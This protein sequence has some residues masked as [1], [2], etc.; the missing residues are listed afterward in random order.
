MASRESSTRR[1]P[2]GTLYN[3]NSDSNP[4]SRS[5][6]TSTK[7]HNS[8]RSNTTN[9]N[10]SPPKS[11][12]SPAAANGGLSRD[13]SRNLRPSNSTRQQSGPSRTNATNQQ[14]DRE[15]RPVQTSTRK[16]PERRPSNGEGAGTTSAKPLPRVRLTD[17]PSGSRGLERKDTAASGRRETELKRSGSLSRNDS[18]NSGRSSRDRD[19]DLT[20]SGS[21]RR[22]DVQASSGS[23]LKTPPTQSQRQASP[24]K[25]YTPP[26]PLAN[27]YYKPFT[28]FK[29][30]D[31]QQPRVRYTDGYERPV[32]EHGQFLDRDAEKLVPM[33]TGSTVAG[34]VMVP[35][36]GSVMVCSRC[37]EP[38]NP[39]RPKKSHKNCR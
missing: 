14:T 27:P 29:P 38:V 26:K 4:A 7:R 12:P 25:A 6:S 32:N 2:P 22:R 30:L 13:N 3:P 18:G 1:P 34:W 33:T 35:D 11:S 15:R 20:R 37:K 8:T 17:N 28:P 23:P 10:P 31:Q 9:R 5:N 39:F 36:R 24:P 16:S 19:R 21:T